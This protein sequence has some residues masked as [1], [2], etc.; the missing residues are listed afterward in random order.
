MKIRTCENACMNTS[1]QIRTLREQRNLSQ[2]G[3]AEAIG[4]S[5]SL[6]AA[7]EAGRKEPGRDSLQ[8]ISRVFGVPMSYILGDDASVKAVAEGPSEV[9]LLEMFRSADAV[10][11]NSVLHILSLSKAKE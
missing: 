10:T 11:Q 4:K 3:F 1:R 5:R 7:W 2:E 9:T 8:A 6:V